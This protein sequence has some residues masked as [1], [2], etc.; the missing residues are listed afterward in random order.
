MNDFTM[1]ESHTVRIARNV[2]A[3]SDMLRP[4][5]ERGRRIGF[6]PTMGAF[7]AGHLSLMRT[8]HAA[9]DVTVVSLFV[10]PT[11]FGDASDLAAY[12]RDEAGDARLAETAGA[13]ILFA[14]D[15]AEMYPVGFDTRVSVGAVALPLEGVARGTSH[16]EGVA[17]VVLKLFN[18]VRPTVAYFGQKDFQQTCV[19]RQFVRDLNVPVD[20]VVR[21]TVREPDGL[22]MSSRNVRLSPAAREQARALSEALFAIEHAV[23][24]GERDVAGLEALGVRALAARDIGPRDIE[25]LAGTDTEKLQPVSRVTGPTLFAVAARV[26]GVRLIDNIIVAPTAT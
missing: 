16:F 24:H 2:T 12:P 8:S 17:T 23:A 13:D 25:Y 14:P 18:M 6:V 21:P 4:H 19:V 9:C 3:L 20:V 10:N 22:A 7:H 5:R 11:Q 1:P 26:G 15:V